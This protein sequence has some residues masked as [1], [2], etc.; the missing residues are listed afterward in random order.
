MN[1]LT[2]LL[3]VASLGQFFNETDLSKAQSL[4][5]C[6]LLG[7]LSEA[8]IDIRRTDGG[9]PDYDVLVTFDQKTIAC[10]ISDVLNVM[11]GPEVPN[12]EDRIRLVFRPRQCFGDDD[13]CSHSGKP[14]RGEEHLSVFGTPQSIRLTLSR[15]GKIIT[16]KSFTPAYK[17]SFPNGK[18]CPSE[19]KNWSTI[20]Y[21]E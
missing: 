11:D 5:T 16:S 12:C 7:C 6:T 2:V 8:Q 17:S 15:S 19:C 18:E 4:K 3:I 10:K 14:N 20:W 1:I 21:V 13:G 9:L